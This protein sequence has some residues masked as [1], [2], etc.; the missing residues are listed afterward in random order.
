M[1][2]EKVFVSYSTSDSREVLA[3]IK[4]LEDAGVTCWYAPRDLATGTRWEDVI[5]GV[6]ADCSAFLLVLSTNSHDSREVKDEFGIANDGNKRIVTLKISRLKL[7]GMFALRLRGLHWIDQGKLGKA[8]AFRQLTQELKSGSG[9]GMAGE[10]PRHRFVDRRGLTVGAG[11]FLAIG[12]VS[13]YVVSNGSRSGQ[14]GAAFDVVV[15]SP[16]SEMR[17]AVNVLSVRLFEAGRDVPPPVGRR[18]S[19]QFGSA[20]SRFLYLEVRFRHDPPR[21]ELRI[22]LTCTIVGGTGEVV[23]DLDLGGT[24]TESTTE[25]AAVGGLGNDTPG[26]WNPGEYRV[27]CRHGDRVVGAATFAVTR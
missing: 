23:A 10:R 25:W 19:S 11:L 26:L 16:G 1:G 18:Y 9:V 7:K 17:L 15:R 21:R 8:E 20:G 22:S 27:Q 14:P 4:S 3:L 24:V 2:E 12:A 6:I 5:P 13:A